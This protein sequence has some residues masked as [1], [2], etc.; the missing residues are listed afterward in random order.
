MTGGDGAAPGGRESAAL[1]AIVEGWQGRRVVV[2][3]DLMLDEYRVGEVERMSPEAPIPV[4]RVAERRC[5][6]GGAGNVA[7]NVASLGANCRLIGVIGED[8]EGE[9][10]AAALAGEAIDASGVLRSGERPTTHKLRVASRDRQLLRLDRESTGPLSERDAAR[11]RHAVEGALA[12][13]DALVLQDYGKGVFAAPETAAL[14]GLARSRGVPV[15]AD[16]KHDLARF[17][18]ADLVKPNE[19]EARRIGAALGAGPEIDRALLEKLRAAIGGGQVV[20]TRGGAGMT[21]LAQDGRRVD[22]ATE[23][24]AVFDVQ[25]AGDTT[26]AALALARLARASLVEACIV[27][28]AA[29][30]VVVEKVGTATVGLAELRARLPRAIAAARGTGVAP[31]EVEEST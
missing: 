27:A 25:G 13:C 28:N 14:V 11:L 16:P 22:V 17:R 9:A 23:R 12:D 15:V 6:L 3:G 31:H 21:A 8:V 19:E 30:S 7:R 1:E 5:A 10:F 20:V 2:V 26:L 29:A 4:V 24:L 18:G